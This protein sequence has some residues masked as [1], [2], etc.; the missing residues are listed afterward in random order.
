MKKLNRRYIGQL[1]GMAAAVILTAGA[2]IASTTQ[3]EA[4][5]SSEVVRVLQL[6][7]VD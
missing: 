2:L 3:T 4:P 6:S 5:V 1:L 7:V